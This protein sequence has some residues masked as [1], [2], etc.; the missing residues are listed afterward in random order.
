[1]IAVIVVGYMVNCCGYS[2]GWGGC[3]QTGIPV[4]VI[5]VRSSITF[6]GI[7]SRLSKA[8]RSRI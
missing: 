8:G 3:V 5:L 4:E 1:M 6:R 7:A 2:T